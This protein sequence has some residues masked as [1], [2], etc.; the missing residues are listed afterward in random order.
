[1]IVIQIEV[2]GTQTEWTEIQIAVTVITGESLSN[3]ILQLITNLT[4]SA[5]TNARI[6]TEATTETKQEIPRKEA[7]ILALLD[8]KAKRLMADGMLAQGE[9]SHRNLLKTKIALESQSQ[10]MKAK[11]LERK[12]RAVVLLD[13]IAVA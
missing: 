10:G 13:L 12:T 5:K 4:D 3:P 7:K 8:W 6:T 2:T 11:I 9:I 1:M